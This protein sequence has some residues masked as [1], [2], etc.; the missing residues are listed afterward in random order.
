MPNFRPICLMP[1][2]LLAFGLC[3]AVPQT[4]SAQT[5]SW[6]WSE[7][8]SKQGQVIHL[9]KEITVDDRIV[10]AKLQATADNHITVFVNGKAVLSN[11][12]WANLAV[13]DITKH[14][15]EK[16]FVVSATARNDGGIAAMLLRL[17]IT[18]KNGKKKTIVSDASWK[19]SEDKSGDWQKVGF[20]ETAWS[21]V[22]VLGKLGMGP[23]GDVTKNRIAGV[24]GEATAAENIT[25]LPGFEVER[26]YSVPKSEQGS[27]V[28]M[29]ADPQ[30]RLICCDQGGGL[31]RVT[32]GKDEA[33]TTVEKL[34]A[35][36]GNAQGLLFAY[37]SLY[38]SVNGNAAQGS[39]FY[40]LKDTN[41]DDQF[42]EVKLLK[43]L[44]GGGEHGPHAIRLGPDGLLYVIAGNHTSIPEG[45]EQGAPHRNWAED[46]LLKRNPDGRGHATGKMAPGGWIAR[47]DKD[48][49]NWE[50][51]CAGFRNPYD[52]DF[53]A[54]GELF[55]Y[56]ADMEYD[57]GSPWYRPTRVSHC[58]VGAEMGWR[59]GTGKWPD[60]FVD[61]RGAVVDIG[62]GSPT[63]IE[64]GTGAK[65]P[66]KYQRA[67][68]INDWTYGIV[69]AVHMKP[70]GAS[71]TATFEKFIT[72]RPLPMT[73]ICVNP[74]DHAMYFTIGGR[75]TQSGLYRVTYSG[76]AKVN[77][78]SDLTNQAGA[79]ARKL[80]REIESLVTSEDASAI[81]TIWPNLRSDDRAIRYAA[82]VA[83][84]NKPLDAWRIKAFADKNTNTILQT[85]TALCRAGDKTDQ[86]GVLGKLNSLP[87]ARMS[88]EQLVDAL[89][90]YSLAYIRLGGKQNK[91]INDS[92]AKHLSPFY[93]SESELV[94]RELCR[95]LVYLE[96]PTVVT[97]TMK[98]LTQSQTQQD[99]M[100]YAFVLRNAKQGWS[101]PQLRSY[102]SWMNVAGT[103]YRGGASFKAFVNQ[104]R[105]DAKSLLDE[106]Q[107]TALTE[108]IEGKETEEVVSFETT[109]QFVHNWQ[110]S[111]LVEMLPDVEQGRSFENGA[112]V[113]A[114]T[115]CAKCHRFAGE[116]GAT[117]PDITGVGSRFTPLYLLEAM[118]EPSK[119]VSD[120]YV[121]SIIQTEDGE[122]LV[123]RI[124]DKTDALWKVR[125]HP[126]ARELTVVPVDSIE[127]VK[128]SSVSEM[129]KGLLNT[130][131]KEEI[132]D[133]IAYM[134]SAGNAEDAAF[135]K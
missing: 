31:Y 32:P 107:I 125:T 87:M 106:K 130:L 77:L 113:Y 110:V 80:R 134:R 23:W 19:T 131:T 63:G 135:K 6:I 104:I 119:V 10:T 52:M 103:K 94:N 116:G 44:S 108:V 133:L 120:Q 28:S 78:N 47:T 98:L 14:T 43:K 64:F 70:Q 60:Y 12:E 20:N 71:Y 76:D 40:R 55:A 109:R 5:P 42:D 18:L 15:T 128:V 100:F 3:W 114:A 124:I 38:V 61:T 36:I 29:T 112:K 72:G 17:E 16:K 96:D 30:G 111:D 93:P 59:F 26:L 79:E 97:K 129:P 56:D 132:L 66:E 90:V 24:P 45:S 101:M 75:G 121:N 34:T 53:N 46:L 11:D 68:Y 57:T 50:L 8:N 69:Y 74:V 4:T 95:V 9:R 81:A 49:N 73:D 48:G 21:P 89:R 54:D 39:G 65:F 33:S 41:G 37:D 67:L 2:A 83:L 84:E 7:S 117:G 62:L 22:H 123:G 58:T 91:L 85:M 82:R 122:L 127:G 99:Q 126:F 1:A 102:F 13:A 115:Q 51:F 88:E 25:T 35:A 27:W 92:V 105:D 118:I 86:G